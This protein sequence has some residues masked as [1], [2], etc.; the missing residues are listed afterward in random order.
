MS[1]EDKKQFAKEIL[2]KT[3]LPI[4][5]TLMFGLRNT[6]YLL[7]DAIFSRYISSNQ[8]Y[9]DPIKRHILNSLS[10]HYRGKG[11]IYY[12]W[13]TKRI[14]KILSIYGISEFSNSN[15]KILELGC[16]YAEIGSFFSH[17]GCSVLSIDG[18]KENINIMC[19]KSRTSK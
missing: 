2:L 6:Y 13:T 1:T 12:E 15:L 17:L 19:F 5:N 18:R 8:N 7:C 3:K 11:G 16:N 10:L 9:D 14:N 4:L